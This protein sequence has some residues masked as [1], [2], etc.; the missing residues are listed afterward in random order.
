MLRVVAAL[1]LLVAAAF[2]VALAAAS[3]DSTS[4]VSVPTPERV[5]AA[6][7]WPTKPA[8][9]GLYAGTAICAQCHASIVRSQRRSQMFRTF[10]PAAQFR[11]LLGHALDP[12]F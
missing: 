3:S 4:A 10:G 5:R 8:D 9:P 1:S 11:K 12:V 7:W 6:A 2:W